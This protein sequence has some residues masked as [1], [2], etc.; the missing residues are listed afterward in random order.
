[1]KTLR[2]KANLIYKGNHLKYNGTSGNIAKYYFPTLQI[3]ASLKNYKH[4]YF[5]PILQML[6]RLKNY[7]HRNFLELWQDQ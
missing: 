2:T 6:A 3:L 4:H 1:M 5:H 7:K